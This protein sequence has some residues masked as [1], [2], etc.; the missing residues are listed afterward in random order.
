MLDS[1]DFYATSVGTIPIV[2][3]STTESLGPIFSKAGMTGITD[4][5][6]GADAAAYQIEVQEFYDDLTITDILYTGSLTV[7]NAATLNFTGSG[8]EVTASGSNGVLINITGGGGE[9]GTSGTSGSS[10]SS[11]TSGIDGSSGSSGTSG[12]D[13]SSGS[14]G[15]SGSSRLIGYFRTRWFIRFIRYLRY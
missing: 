3:L 4:L 10:G 14:S 6:A 5:P 2:S 11:G 13:G 1:G 7:K 15:T 9:A 8:I 12:A